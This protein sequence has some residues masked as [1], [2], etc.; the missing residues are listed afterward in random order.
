MITHYDMRNKQ[1]NTPPIRKRKIEIINIQAEY[2]PI[3]V[4]FDAEAYK[5]E[6]EIPPKISIAE[7]WLDQKAPLFYLF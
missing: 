1:H 7:I 5:K 2:S 6:R 3:F 4:A